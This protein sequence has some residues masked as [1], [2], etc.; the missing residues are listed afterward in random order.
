MVQIA[1]VSR[2]T[3]TPTKSD[4]YT[5]TA[6]RVEPAAHSFATLPVSFHSSLHAT[7]ERGEFTEAELATISR[8]PLVTI[9]RHLLQQCHPCCC[10]ALSRCR[11]QP[12]GPCWRSAVLAGA[13][14]RA[15]GPAGAG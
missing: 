6:G 8:F 15:V 1:R 13:T 3:G 7:N 2:P 10:R 11:M 12:P 14:T 4:D 5:A 9:V